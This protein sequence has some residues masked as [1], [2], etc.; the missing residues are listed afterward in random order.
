MQDSTWK[1]LNLSNQ[2]I[3][4]ACTPIINSIYLY[5]YAIKLSTVFMITGITAGA[6]KY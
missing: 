3:S 1:I 6:I 5:S 4:V 2:N